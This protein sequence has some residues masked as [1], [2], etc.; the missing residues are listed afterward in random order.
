MTHL[1]IE[2]LK[3]LANLVE[4]IVV[5]KYSA[6]IVDIAVVV[7]N[8]LGKDKVAAEVAV[9]AVV[10]VGL[11]DIAVEVAV[12]AAVVAVAANAAVAAYSSLA[13]HSWHRQQSLAVEVEAA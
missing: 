7:D 3:N 10:E 2:T 9:V 8:H 4:G 6:H 11:A 12:P 1:S 5:E 13:G